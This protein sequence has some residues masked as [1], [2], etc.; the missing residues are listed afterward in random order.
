VYGVHLAVRTFPTAKHGFVLLPRRWVVKRSFAR[1]A[2]FRRL[3]RDGARPPITLAGCH[4][5]VFGI[6][7]LRRIA[8]LITQ[9]A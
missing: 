7:M 9:S 6:L 5:L 2:R 8:E 4:F 1:A 3:A